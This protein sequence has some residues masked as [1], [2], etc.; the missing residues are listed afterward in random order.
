MRAGLRFEYMG[1]GADRDSITLDPDNHDEIP[2]LSLFVQQDSRNGFYPTDGW[3]L[4]LELGKYGLFGGDGDWWRL[5]LDV[6]Q[7]LRIPLLGRRHSLALSSYA[8]LLSGE[9]GT[10]IPLWQEFFIGGTNSVRGW[11]LGVREGQNQWLNTAEYWFRLMEQ[12][13]WKFW[14]IKW[15]MGLQIGV[16][17]D[18]GTAWT[19]YQDLEDNM[20]GGL[21]AG[22]RLTLPVVTM[23][24][25]DVAHSVEGTSFY[26]AIGGGEKA[27]AQKS[28]VR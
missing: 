5:D 3:Y 22:L 10:T 28:R 27:D 25:F 14:F 12:K 24:R 9:L 6:R 7:Y 20:I 11:A 15:R 18:L 1:L 17:G 19:D 21:G 2:S 26:V 23:I 8:A 16:L 4:D 13:K